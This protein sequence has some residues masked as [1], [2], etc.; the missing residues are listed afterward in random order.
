MTK[1]RFTRPV[2]TTERVYTTTDVY[3]VP[4]DEAKKFI[5][6][7]LAKEVTPKEAAAAKAEPEAKPGR[8]SKPAADKPAA[9]L[10]IDPTPHPTGD[11]AA[12]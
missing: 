11:D 5:E 4:G 1:L 12:K 10:S 3:E 6:S 2:S 7:K 8:K 9:E